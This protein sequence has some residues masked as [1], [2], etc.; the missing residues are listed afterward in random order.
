MKLFTHHVFCP[1]LFPLIFLLL[2]T[3][4]ATQRDSQEIIQKTELP[5]YAGEPR[6]EPI[7]LNVLFHVMEN[8]S[9]ADVRLLTKSGDKEW[10]RAVVDSLKKWRFTAHKSDSSVWVSK[11]LNIHL[12]QSQ[13]VNLGELVIK[14]EQDA[15]VLYSRLRAGVSFQQLVS[16][17][18]ENSSDSIRGRYLNEVNT[19]EY[20]THVS[21]I[22]IE[23]G[24]GDY[25]RPVQVDGEYI[26]FKRFGDNLPTLRD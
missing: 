13:I 5:I 6:E 25:T 10:D 4:C 2:T 24:E 19:I 20:P 18:L 9:V 8:G 17:A 14:N 21:K 22:L 7:D 26:I 16:Q 15:N 11:K 12:L 23:L 3:G 1:A